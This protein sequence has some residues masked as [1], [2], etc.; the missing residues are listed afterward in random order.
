M[1]QYG[2]N[3][4][5]AGYSVDINAYR[6]TKAQLRALF[7]GK[8]APDEE[9]TEEEMNKLY[10][11]ITAFISGYLGPQIDAI[12]EIWRQLRGPSGNG[13]EQL[14]QNERGQNLTLVDAVAAIRQQL[15]Q[16][17]ADVNELKRRKK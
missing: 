4:Q 5:V 15:A 16:I 10:R 17:Q 7:S 2:S 1:W 6:G 12:Q 8:P 11:Q 14:G 13:W 9:P 3:A